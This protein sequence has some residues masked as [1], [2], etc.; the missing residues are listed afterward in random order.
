MSVTAR[1]G[2]F[3]YLGLSNRNSRCGLTILPQPEGKVIVILS[4]LAA[5][6][7]ASITN[8]YAGIATAVYEE[9]LSHVPVQ[10]ITWI[11]HYN[12]DSYY[13]NAD[14][15]ES[16][17]VVGLTWDDRKKAFYAPQWH[18]CSKAMIESMLD[19]LELFG[20]DLSMV[21]RKGNRHRVC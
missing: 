10:D 16:F 12:R 9:F 18:P 6:P 7:G 14:S 2:I 17:T 19:S 11:E 13:E 21:N 3:D 1:Q 4:E 15:E 8:R 5:N 20:D